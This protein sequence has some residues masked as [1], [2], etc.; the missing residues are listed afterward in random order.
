MSRFRK[1]IELNPLKKGEQQE[2]EEEGREI[3]RNLEK[4]TKKIKETQENNAKADFILNSLKRKSNEKYT[5]EDL[6]EEQIT[7]SMKTNQGRSLVI[8]RKPKTASN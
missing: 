2:L 3:V 7:K 8:A 1:E 4:K 6:S 5:A